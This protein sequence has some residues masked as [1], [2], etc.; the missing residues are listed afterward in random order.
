MAKLNEGDVMEGIFAICLADIFAH[1]SI[2]KGNVNKIRRE[3]D[4]E[5]FRDGSFSKE[6]WRVKDGSPKDNIGVTLNMRLKYNST[7]EAF[8][9]NYEPLYES[10]NDIGNLDKKINTLVSYVNTHYASKVR[11]V[12]DTYLKN[13]QADEVNIVINADG[14]AGES[15]GGN[16][17]GDLMVTVFINDVRQ[18]D[19]E[20]VF[21][22]KSGSKTLAN[23]SPYNGMKDVIGRFGVQL[24]T[25]DDVKFTNYLGDQLKQAKTP[26]EKK[27]KVKLINEMYGKMLNVT[28]GEDLADVVDIDK[29]KIKEM[30]PEYIDQLEQETTSI[31]T[32]MKPANGKGSNVTLKFHMMPSDKELF[33]LRFKQRVEGLGDDFKIKELKFYVEAGAGAY[34]PKLK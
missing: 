29:T 11:R 22:L 32:V 24:D 4:P 18:M 14:I 8:G 27:L 21:S 20:M 3:I 6:V 12:K 10:S 28:F 1:N 25:A 13:N 34:A 2:N 9:A 33:Q 5:L 7:F 19:T 16:I 31:K 17:K 30:I 26:H 15:S 23:L